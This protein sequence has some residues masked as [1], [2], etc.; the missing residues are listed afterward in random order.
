ME[1]KSGSKEDRSMEEGDRA[2]APYMDEG[3]I[4]KGLF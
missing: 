4:R 2:K 1:L 3:G